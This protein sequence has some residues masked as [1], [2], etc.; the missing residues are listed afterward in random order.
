MAINY[1]KL[2]TDTYNQTK[3][4]IDADYK[5]TLNG[6]NAEEE[7]LKQAY[8]Q[9]KSDAYV[10]AKLNAKSTE[11]R[12]AAQGLQRGNGEATSGYTDI[13][14][15]ADRNAMLRN[16]NDLSAAEQGELDSLA[17]QR[18]QAKND[19][20]LQVGQA[21]NERETNIATAEAQRE[22][23]TAAREADEQSTAFTRALQRTQIFGY[24]ATEEDAKILG[25]PKGTKVSV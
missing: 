17:M 21:V 15:A 2:Y 5:N 11:E 16:I 14:R 18:V 20:N 13:Q 9:D 23:T 7:D 24:V 19:R 22:Q 25:I 10:Q 1:R 6:I 4:G 12:A 3:T 8:R